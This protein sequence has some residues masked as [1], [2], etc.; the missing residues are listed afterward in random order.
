MCG[1]VEDRRRWRRQRGAT[2]IEV[3]L[4]IVVLSFALGSVLG[5]LAL[6]TGRSADP[7]LVRQSLAIAESLLQEVLAQPAGPTD[8]DGGAEGQGPEGGETR[9]S[10]LLPF[11]HVSDYHG[12]S[13]SGVTSADGTAV[14]ALAG[15]QASVSVTP[16]GFDGLP[17][18]YGWL[19][20]VTVTGPDG[21][22]LALQGVRAR[23]E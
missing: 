21:A 14:P 22:T 6:T 5:L 18:A 3:I 4:F 1:A 19:V 17:A 2:L 20:T 13:M 11:D 7:L 8:P 10:A 16:Q 12:Y 23:T 9:G 15:Y